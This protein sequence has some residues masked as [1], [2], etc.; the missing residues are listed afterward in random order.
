MRKITS[1]LIAIALAAGA[2]APLDAAA[3]EKKKKK[4][5]GSEMTYERK[6][7]PNYAP[8]GPYTVTNI[9]GGQFFEGRVSIAIEA[10]DNAARSAIWS[11]KPLVNGIVQPLAVKLFEQGRPTPSRIEAFKK[12]AAIKLEQRFK[13]KIKGIYV[14]EVMG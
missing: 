9:Q 14:R 1:L 3:Q 12:E 6:L 5:D 11:N 10:V 4:A 8:F 2:L 13:D 7:P